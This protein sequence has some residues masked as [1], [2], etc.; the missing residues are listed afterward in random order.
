MW[1]VSRSHQ[2]DDRGTIGGHAVLRVLRR[3]PQAVHSTSQ[4]LEEGSEVHVKVDWRRWF[5]HMQ[6]HSG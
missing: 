1:C 4:P 2:P 5:D 6:Q 3:G